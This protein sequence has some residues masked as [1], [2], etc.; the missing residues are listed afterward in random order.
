MLNLL[1]KQAFALVLSQ[2]T[3]VVPLNYKSTYGQ[4]MVLS[5]SHIHAGTSNDWTREKGQG[6]VKARFAREN[7]FLSGLAQTSLPKKDRKR[8]GLLAAPF[9]LPLVGTA[10]HPLLIGGVLLQTS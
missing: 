7:H 5:M 1:G 2:F 6:R 4:K 9:L 10:A 8:G 3:S